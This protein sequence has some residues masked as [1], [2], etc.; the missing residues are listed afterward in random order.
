MV[1]ALK[2]NVTKKNS[3]NNLLPCKTSEGGGEFECFSVHM[4]FHKLFP[5]VD[6]VSFFKDDTATENQ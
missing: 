5:I 3:N 4:S 1:K 2:S 6:Q